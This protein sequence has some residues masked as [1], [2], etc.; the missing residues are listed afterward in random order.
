MPLE[1]LSRVVDSTAVVPWETLLTRLVVALGLGLVINLVYHRTRLASGS[2][3]TFPTTLVLLC[4]LIAM[5]T[6]V[7]GDN[8][9][10]A[11]SL[12]G[13]LSIVRFRTVVRDTKDTAF[14]I[15]A[16]VVGMAVGAGQ[17]VVALCGIAV[18]GF[19]SMLLRDRA[20]MLLE[21]DRESQLTVRYNWAPALEAST[22]EC[23]ARY[24]AEIEPMSVVTVRH[25]AAMEL[26]YRL[27]LLPKVRPTDLVAELNRMEGMQTV[28]LHAVKSGT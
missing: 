27:R 1:W 8:V 28:E 26:S 3:G 20:Q 18:V 22:L 11:F 13:A 9:A 12:V 24:A 4:V 10:R 5:V 2:A 23:V 6:Q 16:V 17:P 15:F 7:I 21:L 19:A 25:G 14:V